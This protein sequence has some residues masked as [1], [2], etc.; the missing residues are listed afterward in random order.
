MRAYH[1]AGLLALLFWQIAPAPPRDAPR[2]GGPF[3]LALAYATGEWEDASFDC[4][5]HLTGSTAVPTRSAGAKF[6][7]L[8]SGG[9][10]RVTAV[11]GRW[12]TDNPWYYGPDGYHRSVSHDFAGLQLA[13]EGRKIGF[14]I[15]VAGHPVTDEGTS[16][17][18]SV[19]ARLGDVGRIHFQV[20]VNPPT[21]TPGM[22]GTVRFGLGFGKGLERRVNGFVGA[23]WG[24]YG[25]QFQ[26]EVLVAD[27]GI[28]LSR[29]FDL[30][31]RG[32]AGPGA[33]TAQWATGG[34]LRVVW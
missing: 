21:E 27:I 20:D 9:A 24:P 30:L 28:P 19:Y 7:Y 33:G 5:G 11:G 6:E 25:E 34:G 4:N 15:G 12:W 23:A 22:M 3:R 8:G 16:T 31:I 26:Q 29:S 14:G 13:L 1:V 18:A 32:S 17:M 10:L 2:R